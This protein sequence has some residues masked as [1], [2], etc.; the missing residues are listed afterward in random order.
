MRLPWVAAFLLG[1][2]ISA[3]ACPAA[4][5]SPRGWAVSVYGL[6]DTGAR[7]GSMMGGNVLEAGS[8]TTMP[9]RFAGLPGIRPGNEPVQLVI[10]GQFRACTAGSYAFSL[11][12]EAGRQFGESNEWGGYACW[13][14]LHQANNK[15]FSVTEGMDLPTIFSPQT[16]RLWSGTVT[17]T[18]GLHPLRLRLACGAA[19]GRGWIYNQSQYSQDGAFNLRVIAPGERG[20]RAFR[21]DEI[22]Q[23][24]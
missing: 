8:F 6:K 21:P 11:M 15:L 1:M 5:D 18:E 10:E 23:P 3:Q 24:Q 7:A 9:R 13:G 12:I 19:G 17:L 14:E 16:Q 2:T 20:P 22:Y 4:P